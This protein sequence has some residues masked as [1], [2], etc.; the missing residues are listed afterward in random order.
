[1]RTN[2]TKIFIF[3]SIFLILV[4]IV[5]FSN[6][7]EVNSKQIKTIRIARNSITKKILFEGSALP[8]K[9]VDVKPNISGEI[10]RIHFKP[11]DVVKEGEVLAEIKPDPGILLEL[12]TKENDRW[13]AET[14]Y[15]KEKKMYDDLLKLHEK[16]YISP[17]ELQEA[18]R[19]YETAER[20]FR[21]SQKSTEFYRKKYGLDSI[22]T[23]QLIK[24][25]SVIRAPI[26]GTVLRNFVNTGDYCKSALSQYAEGTTLCII[27]DLSSYIVNLRVP[28]SDLGAIFQG[29]GVAVYTKNQMRPDSGFV[30]QLSPMGNIESQ[31]ITFDFSIFFT[32]VNARYRPGSTVTVEIV[33]KHRENI[34]TVPV[35]AIVIQN[36]KKL[37]YVKEMDKY[38]K[39]EI[40]IGIS[41]NHKV[42]VTKGLNL[43]DEIVIEPGLLTEK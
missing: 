8:Y 21:Y 42:E 29:Q 38:S 11:G 10:V 15:F 3:I 41:D 14:D 19:Q 32:P 35:G 4:T 5:F 17:E 27:G 31:P 30:D 37:V 23:D 25:N 16:K 1:M 13:K 36:R 26:S 6:N 12:F 43:D 28:E 34:L 39:H 22:D 18:K 2:K 9:M 24:S 33:L 7:P 20:K 40:S